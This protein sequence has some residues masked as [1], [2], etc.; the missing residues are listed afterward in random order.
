MRNLTRL[1]AAQG[2]VHEAKRTFNLYVQLVSKARQTSAGDVNLQLKRRATTQ[3]AV[4]PD[5][6]AEESGVDA[7][8]GMDEDADDDLTFTEM[9][10]WGVSMLAKI[11]PHFADAQEVQKVA[12]L[13]RSVV[14]SSSELKDNSRFLAKVLRA[15]GI[16][17]ATVALR[18]K[19]LPKI[20]VHVIVTSIV[21]I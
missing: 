11:S 17:S 21:L 1:L 7:K 2:S 20:L 13:A 14:E 16:A 10:V 9:L 8:L 15:E 12:Q 4:H 3:P 6:I 19:Y 5:Q 18:G